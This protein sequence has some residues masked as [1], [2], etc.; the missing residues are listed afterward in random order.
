MKRLFFLTLFILS[1]STYTIAKNSS[2]NTD[3]IEADQAYSKSD[4]T[5]AIKI[6]ENILKNGESAQVYYNIGNCYYKTNEIAKAMLNYE[7]ALLLQ[8]SNDDIRNNLE[9]VRSKTIDK[10]EPA[11]EIF[12]VTWIKELINLRS[13]DQWA[14][15][16]IIFFIAFIGAIYFYF[17]GK[18]I[19]LR[20]LGFI[21][22]FTFFIFA[23]LSNI[24][25]YKQKN[26]LIH[27]NKAI[28]VN[29]IVTVRST[30]S[31]NGTILFQI[32]EGRKVSIT[33]NSMSSWKEITLEDGK[34]GW[35]HNTNL[36]VI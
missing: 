35:I 30:P 31:D 6:Y 5:K 28:I 26:E 17:W 4:Y 32:H 18:K 27:R 25:A 9:I 19:K 36:E 12:F 13:V 1:I 33:D 7:R 21:T 15:I 14:K 22:G 2:I 10:V 24:F 8:P 29:H 20:K 34:V 16:G 11:P 23:L 3:K